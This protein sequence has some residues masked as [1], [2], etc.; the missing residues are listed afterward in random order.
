MDDMSIKGED[1]ISV[2]SLICQEKGKLFIPDS[3]RQDEVASS[4]ANHYDG[5][6]L[7]DAIKSYIAS[8]QGPI[9][10]FDFAIKSR[11]IVEKVKK[12]RISLERFK[13]TVADTR[14]LIQEDEL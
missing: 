9:L 13:Q 4:L 11:D 12:E 5:D 1:V 10:V 14:K 6:D 7:L 3:P 8:E 2:F